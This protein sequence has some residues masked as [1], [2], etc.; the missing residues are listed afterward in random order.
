MDGNEDLIALAVNT[1]GVVVVFV[2]LFARRSELNVDVFGDARWDHSLL[3]VPYFEV[4]GLR[5]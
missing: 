4:R 2:T 5:R 1:D 3:V